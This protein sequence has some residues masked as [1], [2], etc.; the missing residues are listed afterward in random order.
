EAAEAASRTKDQF[1]AALSHELRT[2]LTPALVCVTALVEDP[3]TP[4]A[5]RPGLE[6][7]RRN[8]GLEAR[9][10]DDLLDVTRISRGKLRLAREVADA[11]ELIL[12]AVEICHDEIA[13]AGLELDLGLDAAAHH[14]DADPAR[15]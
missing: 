12:R 4:E 15:F 2:P 7:I 11:H 1:L 10:I 14:V 6:I 5:I 8:I 13:T 9:L 3:E